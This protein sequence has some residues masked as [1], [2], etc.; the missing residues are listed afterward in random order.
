MGSSYRAI[1]I[2]ASGTIA[3]DGGDSFGQ[4]WRFENGT[5]E[6]LGTLAGGVRST[7]A[8]I[9]DQGEIVGTSR[10]L[11][12]MDPPQSFRSVPGQALEL[13]LSSSQA[14]FLNN[15]GQVA[16]WTSS[17]AGFLWT[18][19]AGFEVL[20]A[21]GQHVYVYPSSINSAGDVV[22]IATHANGNASI[23]FL[24]TDDAGMQAIT[25]FTS[26]ASAVAVNDHRT[27]VGNL[28]AGARAGLPTRAWPQRKTT[29]V[30]D[31]T[32]VSWP[33]R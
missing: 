19:G 2:N 30:S 5:F 32:P 27:V 33:V 29:Q 28:S 6:F 11:S 13:V 14:S 4:A 21:L 1:G 18:P 15:A 12:I 16:G 31:R 10:T 23:P 7:A 8:A 22:G 24:F 25:G 20:P 17:L 26:N 3:G 9:N